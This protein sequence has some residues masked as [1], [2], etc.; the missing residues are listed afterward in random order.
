LQNRNGLD[1]GV[2]VLGQEVEEEFR[3]EKA[4]DCAGDLIW[5]AGQFP[6]LEFRERDSQHADVRTTRR[7]QWFLIS[8][9]MLLRS[10]ER[11]R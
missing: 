4:F 2:E 10:A 3:P 11:Q 7:A 5:R 6:T 8:L 9:P 1:G